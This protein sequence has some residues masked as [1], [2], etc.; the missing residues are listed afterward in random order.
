PGSSGGT[1]VLPDDSLV[2]SVGGTVTFR[3]NITPTETPLL[4]VIWQKK[5]GES[6]EPIITSSPAGNATAPEYED[7]ITVFMFTGALE[8]RNLKLSDSGNYAI[9]ILLPNGL[10]ELGVTTLNIYA[11]VSSVVVTP[12][13]AD[14]VEFNSSARLSC[15][16]SGSSLSFLWMNSSSE[17]TASDRVQITDGGSTLTIISVTRYDQGPYSCRVSNPVSA[18]TSQ[19]VNLAISYGPENIQSNISP[20]KDHY[21]EGSDITLSCSAESEPS[22]DFK[23]L[24]DGNLLPDS[25]PELRLMNVQTSQSGNYTCQAFNSKTLRYQTSQPSAVSVL[26]RV[27]NVGVTPPTADL[28]EFNSSVRLSCSSSGSS[29]SF[30]WMNSSSELTDSDRVQITD[31]GSTLTIISVTRYDQGPYSCRVSNPINAETSEPVNLSISYGPENIQSNA[32]PSKDHYE[33]GSD[34]TLSCS[35]ESEP[36]ADFKWLLDGNLLPDS[37]PELRLMNVQMSQS[38]NYTCQAFNSKTLRYQ[39]SQPSAVSVLAR[40]SNVVVKSDTTDLVESKSS[41]SLFCSS[42]GSSPIF[43]WM[44][45][46]SDITTSDRVQIDTTDGGSNLTIV[47]VTRYD[48]GSFSCHVSNYVSSDNSGPVNIFI[49]Y[50]PEQVK[51]TISPH[52]ETFEEGSDILLSCSADSRPDAMFQWFFN[53]GSLPDIGPELSLKHVT[54]K[55]SGDYSCQAFNNKTQTYEESQ[56]AVI[57]VH[58]PSSG[59]SA[60]IIAAVVIVCLI[61]VA[62]LGVGYYIYKKNSTTVG[63]KKQDN[64][65]DASEELHYADLKF[66]K[67]KKRRNVK[68]EDTTT[69]YAKI[70]V[71]TG[72][73]ASFS[74]KNQEL[75]PA[76][77]SLPKDNRSRPAQVQFED[78]SSNYAQIRVNNRPEAS[79]SIN[80]QELNSADLNLPKD[81]RSR[82]AQVQFEDTSSNYAQIRVNNRPPASSSI[83][84]QQLN[85]A[86]LNLPKNDRVRPAQVEFEDA[87]SNYAQIR[88]NKNKP[89]PPPPPTYDV[90]MQRGTKPAPQPDVGEQTSAPYMNFPDPRFPKSQFGRTVSLEL[91]GTTTNFAPTRGNSSRPPPPPPPTYKARLQRE[92]VPPPHDV[93]AQIYA[94]VDKSQKRLM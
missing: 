30:L 63:A 12:P 69:E 58:G 52:G 77:L 18:E 88:V 83:K 37:G 43:L 19:P 74:F 44:N 66:L 41:L 7:R 68:S 36:S 29:L 22:A 57:Y 90:H 87:S 78:F 3:T 82:P 54:I 64:T 71:N 6:F 27:S 94:Q 5:H 16:S 81:D 38:G 73:P 56:S 72:P 62:G 89:P 26:V 34:I 51:L 20:L 15:S 79:S 4:F 49:S 13:T 59:V 23:W 76:D 33:E 31:G 17:L 45:S 32:S 93:N 53:Q 2:A 28:V 10:Q 8:L 48:H 39:T 35:A 70:K 55:Q 84:N 91:N 21:E 50:G 67:S 46:S 47:N 14:L 65:A 92:N 86:D 61:F 11:P 42:A 75:N 80:N 1:G 24:L 85:S 60:G 40:I 25:G 9:D